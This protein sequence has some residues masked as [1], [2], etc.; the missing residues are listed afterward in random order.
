[1]V[2]SVSGVDDQFRRFSHTLEIVEIISGNL[3]KFEKFQEIPPKSPK[4]T[5]IPD[6]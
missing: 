1:M 2:L 6:S 3:P 5:E 4:P